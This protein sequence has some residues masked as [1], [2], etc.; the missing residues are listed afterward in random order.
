MSEMQ[1][2]DWKTVAEIASHLA[3]ALGIV[4]AIF[5]YIS[6][7]VTRRDRATDILFQL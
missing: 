4:G 5:F 2:S 6:W 7:R 3:Q 1:L